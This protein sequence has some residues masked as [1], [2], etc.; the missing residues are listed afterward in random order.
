MTSHKS[1]SG[2][3][4]FGADGERVT[5]TGTVHFFWDS[6]GVNDGHT[7]VNIEAD[8]SLLPDTYELTGELRAGVIDRLKDGARIAIDY[9]VEPHEI[10]D[11]DGFTT[12]G[13]R[14]RIVAVRVDDLG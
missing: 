6:G 5:V 13:R 12:D 10:V 11:H 2:G 14:P 9:I 4:S 1:L 7:M 8:D 3:S